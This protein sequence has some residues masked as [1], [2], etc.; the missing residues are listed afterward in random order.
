M[1]RITRRSFIAGA[2]AV[3]MFRNLPSVARPVT[4]PGDAIVLENDRLR[5]AFDRKF[6]SL[7]SLQNKQTGWHVQDRSQYGSAFGPIGRTSGMEILRTHS[8]PRL[9]SA[10]NRIPNTRFL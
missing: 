1:A 7:L 2:A 4:G 5:A 9:P 3:G 8:E 6:G 10:E